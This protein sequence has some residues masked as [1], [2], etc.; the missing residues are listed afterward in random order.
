MRHHELDQF[1]KR[2][3]LN[4]FDPRVKLASVVVLIAAI[5]FLRNPLPLFLCLAF[6]LALA[7]V[8]RV[9][10]RHMAKTYLM[11]LPFIVFSSLTLW[12]SSGAEEGATM[13]LRISG[14]VLALIV[15]VTTT[16]FFELLKALRWYRLPAIISSV[17]LF[18]YRFIFVFVDELERMKLARQARGFAGG[19]S[20]LSTAALR[21]IAYTAGMILVRSST[22]ANDIYDALLSRGYMGEVRTLSSFKAGSTDAAF[23]ATFVG[24]AFLS[25]SIQTGVII[26]TI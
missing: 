2:S 26:W 20:L 5:A 12:Y 19:R 9:P 18:T 22:R 17:I 4:R 25:L 3:P 15:L 7:A 11:A 8:S 23:A 14:S 16:P 10:A 21:T 1:A 24:I 6:L 13:F